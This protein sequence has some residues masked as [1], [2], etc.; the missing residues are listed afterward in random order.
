MQRA[1]VYSSYAVARVHLRCPG[2]HGRDHQ[3]L[4]AF[5][6][7]TRPHRQCCL[8]RTSA[9][10]RIDSSHRTQSTCFQVLHQG[11]DAGSLPKQTLFRRSG[12]VKVLATQHWS[13]RHISHPS[14][15]RW[16]TDG[17]LSLYDSVRGL[18]GSVRSLP[19]AEP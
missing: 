15:V 9:S 3:P 13:L 7:F 10:V 14:R 12:D 4:G 6:C 19:A 8:T 16:R 18:S 2:S 5:F 1:K 17:Y 11:A